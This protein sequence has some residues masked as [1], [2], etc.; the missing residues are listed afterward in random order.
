MNNKEFSITDVNAIESKIVCANCEKLLN[1]SPIFCYEDEES[2]VKEICGRCSHILHIKGKMWR[3]QSFENFAQYFTYPCCNKK[4]GCSEVLNWNKVLDHEIV[5]IYR[6]IA[7]PVSSKELFEANSC[8]WTGNVT[9]ISEHIESCHK[10]LIVNP[11]QFDFVEPFTNSIFF[12]RVTSRLITVIIKYE[13]NDIF[14]SLVMING[15]DIESQ[16]YR[17]QLELLNENKEN[18]LILRRGRLEPLSCL[19]DALKNPGRMLEINLNRIK[20]MLKQPTQV[21]GRFGIV[22][23]N[24][25]EISLIAGIIEHPELLQAQVSATSSKEKVVPAPDECMLQEL[26]CPVCNEYMIPPIY[27][28]QTGKVIKYSR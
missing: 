21:I 25:K 20:E 4:F 27:I 15:N 1:V 28:C 6:S 3:Q 11:P 23:K 18:S 7:C 26:E 10:D 9:K 12:T 13:G 22:R 19:T 17:Y 24:K 16:C 5:C 2:N 14:Y 8:N